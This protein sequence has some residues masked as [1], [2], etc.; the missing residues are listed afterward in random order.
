MGVVLKKLYNESKDKRYYGLWMLHRPT[1]L[2]ND[3]NLIKQV[4]ATNF[5]NFH[6]HGMNYDEKNDPFTGMDS[7]ILTE[8]L[9]IV[10]MIIS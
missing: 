9:I 5:K 1:L 8:E 6:S 2:I 3:I 10:R 4:L 7:V